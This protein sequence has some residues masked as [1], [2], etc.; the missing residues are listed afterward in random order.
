[1]GLLLGRTGTSTAHHPCEVL[2]VESGHLALS[3]E[4]EVE[5][6][7]LLLEVL[8]VAAFVAE[9]APAVEFEGLVGDA[10]EE[11]A[12]VRDEQ[13]CAGVFLQ[14]LLQP[15]HHRKV[16]M[17]GRLIQNQ[18]V[19][20]REDGGCERSA[21]LLASREFA[22]EDV[23]VLDAEAEQGR[24]HFAFRVPVVFAALDGGGD[25]CED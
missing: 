20:G 16:K 8:A 15:V 6:L 11:V 25:I 4:G 14:I 7:L 3:R 9:G 21:L 18:Q 1:M 24:A 19:A 5:A 17:I 22:G 12:V 2:A 23:R 13:Q 10:V